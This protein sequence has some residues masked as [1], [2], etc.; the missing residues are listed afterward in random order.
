MSASLHRQGLCRGGY[1]TEFVHSYTDRL[2]NRADN[3]PAIG[4]EKVLFEADFP[5]NADRAGPYLS[6]MALTD[7]LISEFEGRD[8]EKPL[9]LFGLSMENHQ[10]L[11]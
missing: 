3:L 4:F 2:Y 10:P 6:D 9:L 7:M 8:K 11:F 1:A 5:E